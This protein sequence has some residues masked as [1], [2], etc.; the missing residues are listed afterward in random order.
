LVE[1][2]AVQQEALDGVVLACC[3]FRDCATIVV[4]TNWAAKAYSRDFL[5]AHFRLTR[6]CTF[7]GLFSK[8]IKID[9]I[10]FAKEGEMTRWNFG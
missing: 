1:V 9:F 10:Y 8:S 5:L 3:S 7:F 6:R 4:G 2:L